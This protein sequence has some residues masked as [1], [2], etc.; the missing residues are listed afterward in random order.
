MRTRQNHPQDSSI[1]FDAG[2]RLPAGEQA[3]PA[4]L[5]DGEKRF[6]A[7]V[8][9]ELRTPLAVQRALLEL[10]LSDP[11]TDVAGWRQIGG[12]VLG[13]CRQQERILAACIT[14]SRS[15]AGLGACESVDLAVL[16]AELLRTT[17]LE[18]LTASVRLEHASTTG[19]PN[20]IERLLDNLLANAVSHNTVGGWIAL[21]NAQQ[22]IAC[23]SDDR[24]QRPAHSRRRC[25]A[26][27]PTIREALRERHRLDD[28]PGPWARCRQDGR[29]RTPRANHR[30]RSPSRG[31]TSRGLVPPSDLA[32]N[33]TLDR[34]L[35]TGCRRGTL[36]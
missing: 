3:V 10:A 27:L 19:A 35:V 5:G 17:D 24:E 22:Q 16:A 8:A 11:G 12:E 13:A 18:G 20:L 7:Y 26:T 25:G 6:A 2:S 29:R 4:P 30:T 15:Q 9:H 32:V 34:G 33:D 23:A 21:D 31:S 36:R 28:G 14:L 1:R